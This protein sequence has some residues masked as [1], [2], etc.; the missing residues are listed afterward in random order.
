M[1]Y[2]KDKQKAGAFAPALFCPGIAYITNLLYI[3]DIKKA[4]A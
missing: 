3:R 4:D 1:K 2:L